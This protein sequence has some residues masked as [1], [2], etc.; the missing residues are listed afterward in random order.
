MLA[1]PCEGDRCSIFSCN[2]VVI[3]FVQAGCNCTT[4]VAVGAPWQTPPLALQ[5]TRA[6]PTARKGT[7]GELV[8]CGEQGHGKTQRESRVRLLFYNKSRINVHQKNQTLNPWQTRVAFLLPMAHAAPLPA[9]IQLPGLR[10][11]KPST[12][13]P[14]L[15]FLHPAKEM[16]NRVEAVWVYKFAPVSLLLSSLDEHCL[17][18]RCSGLGGHQPQGCFAGSSQHAA[19]THL[20]LCPGGQH[21]HKL[22]KT[23]STTEN[24]HILLSNSAQHAKPLPA[25]ANPAPP[26]YSSSILGMGKLR[27]TL[28]H[29]LFWEVGDKSVTVG[30]ASCPWLGRDTA[31]AVSY[32]KQAWVNKPGPYPP[33][34]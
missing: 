1:V 32:T 25:T 33:C 28:V 13:A 12:A 29:G 2:A 15:K 26:P 3:Y 4:D 22:Q 23:Q 20:S 16:R 31:M 19:C 10:V 27:H 5:T 17:A 7:E 18:M 9:F 14:L 21:L 11:S 8:G 30:G 34:G 6:G 24:H